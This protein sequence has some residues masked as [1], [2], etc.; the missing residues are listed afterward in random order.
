MIRRRTM[1]T[2]SL[3]GAD[4]TNRVVL[5]LTEDELFVLSKWAVLAADH[6][7]ATEDFRPALSLSEKVEKLIERIPTR[8]PW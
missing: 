6:A 8:R 7:T 1:A 2:P 3:S 5:E 4:P